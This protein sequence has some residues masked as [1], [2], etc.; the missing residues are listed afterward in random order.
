MSKQL[1]LFGETPK[2]PRV[3]KG[4]Y[5]ILISPDKK[6][7]QNLRLLREKLHSKISLT[8]ENLHSVPHISLFKIPYEGN[9]DNKIIQFVSRKLEAIKKFTIILDGLVIFSNGHERSLVYKIRNA[10][11]INAIFHLLLPGKVMKTHFTP[12]LTLVKTIPINDFN[13]ISMDLSELQYTGEF[14]C[15]KITILK[16]TVEGKKR[17]RYHVLYEVPLQQ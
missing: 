15:D 3:L 9:T 7:D 16:C 10:D 13:K 2:P 12:H 5:F 4:N 8:E 17:S 14:V 1:F 6:T 11:P